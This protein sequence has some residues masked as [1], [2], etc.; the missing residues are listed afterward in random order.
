MNFRELEA[1][2]ATVEMSVAEACDALGV[3]WSQWDGYRRRNEV[4]NPVSLACRAIYHRL[5]PWAPFAVKVKKRS[6]VAKASLANL[7]RGRN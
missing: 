1:W 2:R 5:D 6:S 7:K 3:T 4:P